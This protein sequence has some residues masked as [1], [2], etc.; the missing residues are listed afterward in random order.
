MYENK[1]T[2]HEKMQYLLHVPQGKFFH[3]KKKLYMYMIIIKNYEKMQYVYL[4]VPQGKVFRVIRSYPPTRN[5]SF[6]MHTYLEAL[7]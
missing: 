7:F 6:E 4:H 1:K 3:V 5:I 2:L